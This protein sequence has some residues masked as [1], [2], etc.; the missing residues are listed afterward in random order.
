MTGNSVRF[1]RFGSQLPL[2][3]FVRIKYLLMCINP[4][5]SFTCKIKIVMIHKIYILYLSDLNDLHIVKI[6]IVLHFSHTVSVFSV[7]KWLTLNQ[8]IVGKHPAEINLDK[9]NK[10]VHRL[11]MMNTN[12]DVMMSP[13]A[14]KRLLRRMLSFFGKWNWQKKWQTTITTLILNEGEKNNKITL[15]QNS[16]GTSCSLAISNLCQKIQ[17]FA[18]LLLCLHISKKLVNKHYLAWHNFSSVSLTV[19]KQIKTSGREGSNVIRSYSKLTK[20]KYHWVHS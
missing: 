5:R 15:E 16:Y 19:S 12:L 14:Q 7:E 10:E 18:F 4:L 9:A 11:Q 6:R 1:D 8:G 13:S 3:A 17:R 2:S 20:V